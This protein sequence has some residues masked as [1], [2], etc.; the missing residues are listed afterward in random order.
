M[1]TGNMWWTVD[2]CEVGWC[3]VTANNLVGLV[4]R[5]AYAAMDTLR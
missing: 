5:T 1:A 3:D 4:S 2:G